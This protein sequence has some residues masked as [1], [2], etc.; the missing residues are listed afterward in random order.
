MKSR[1]QEGILVSCFLLLL[2]GA[3]YGFLWRDGS[4]L[5]S[6]YSDNI[7]YSL[8]SK[9]ALFR[10]WQAGEGIPFWRGDQLSGGTALTNPQALYTYPF[11]FLFYLRPPADALG[12]TIWLHFALAGGIFYLLGR[13]LGLSLG[14]RLL[15]GTTGLFNFK[16]LLAAFA[17]WL[18]IIP[19][20]V[21]SPLL[22]LSVLVLV[23]RPGLGSGL[24]FTAASCL[25]LHTG[26]VQLV[27]YT[28]L[29]LAGHLLSHGI[30]SWRQGDRARSRQV[31]TWLVCGGL[32]AVGM[33]AYLLLPVFAEL[34][35]ISRSRASYD[36]F[37]S[38]H[39]MS[40]PHLLTFVYPEALGTPVENSYYAVELWE[41]VAYFGL[42]PLVL[43]LF[44]AVWGWRRPL[45]PMLVISFAVSTFLAM[46]SPVLR[47]LFAVLPGFALFHCPSRFLF[48]TSFFGLALA[49]IG[50]DQILERIGRHT[51]S[52]SWQAALVVALLV[53]VSVE[54]GFY[55]RRYLSMAP[56]EMALPKTEYQSFLAR[57]GSPF[58]IAPIGRSTLN[59]GWSE[60]M[61]LQLVTGY[62][63]YNLRH[64]QTYF[65]L[66]RTGKPGPDAPRVWTDL[67]QIARRDL[68]D[69]L[70]VRYIL[71]AGSL[72]FPDE[73]FQRVS[74][75]PA[76][77]VFSFYEG[78]RYATLHLYRNRHDVAR[79]FWVEQVLAVNSEREA[80][81]EM[82]NRRLHTTA[83]VQ[84]GTAARLGSP[85]AESD[86]VRVAAAGNGALTLELQNAKRRFLVISEVWHPGWRALLDGRELQL[87]RTNFALLGAW[88]PPGSH[89]LVLSF[90]PLL[91]S[92]GL[93]ISLFSGC[94]FLGLLCSWVWRR[95]QAR[96]SRPV[97]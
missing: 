79:A 71:S 42:I 91:W 46:E 28:V 92:W 44:G 96:S 86:R 87:Y 62:D 4:V 35:L 34:P 1:F 60:A 69:A 89:R 45:T 41:D 68:L 77:P 20:I 58:R 51:Q 24:L 14:A 63:P 54:G 72:R 83:I 3:G 85:P 11:H 32:L 15:M 37:L 64:Y 12:G 93:G 17:G 56:R 82:Q 61:G 67:R 47:A 40:W 19:S 97:R 70:N 59:Y 38:G 27:Y 18:P 16:L 65:D 78:T 29:F 8:A 43:A 30:A 52:T 2:A 36:F 9:G 31:A 76:Q 10:S 95:T 13:A 55:A 73:S 22:M 39:A 57:D 84:Q 7:T 88:I 33:A 80:L 21:L 53:A 48:L 81:A 5:Y 94:L 25:C 75:F 90:R 49:G 74:S 26:H 23:R 66:V 50:L 6:E